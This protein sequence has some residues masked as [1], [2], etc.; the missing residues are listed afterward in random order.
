[1]IE[2]RGSFGFKK[3]KRQLKRFRGIMPKLVAEEAVNHFNAGF[4]KGG[5]QTDKSLTGWKPRKPARTPREAQRN[6]GR[7]ILVRSGAMRSD[8][9]ART[10]TP[11]KIVVN[12]IHIPYAGFHNEGSGKIPQRE[13]IGHSRVLRAKT[14]RLIDQQL[15]RIGI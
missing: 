11:R 4:R 7:A 13:F 3:M 14:R 9:K 12:V 1:M 8:I 6:Q 10:I 5:G 15:K 2:K